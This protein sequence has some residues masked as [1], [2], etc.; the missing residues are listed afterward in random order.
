MD[1]L[2]GRLKSSGIGC[3]IGNQFFGGFGYADDL[4]LLCPSIGGL[5]KMIHIC[6]KFEKEYD[7]MFNA[8]KTIGICYGD[9]NPNEIRPI[10]SMDWKNARKNLKNIRDK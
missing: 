7:V 1:E 10:Q 8:K 3:C 2:I 6:E 4:K 9:V 5:Q